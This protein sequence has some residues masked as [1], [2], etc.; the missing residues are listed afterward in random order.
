MNTARTFRSR[1][2]KMVAVG[3]GALVVAA[4]LFGAYGA[5]GG[6]WTSASPAIEYLVPKD[7]LYSLPGGQFFDVSLNVQK[8]TTVSGQFTNTKGITL[9][10]MTPTE[11]TYLSEKGT[12][13]SYYW[14][15]GRIAN[16][17]L[18]NFNYTFAPGQWGLV[19]LNADNP[20][21]VNPSINTTIVTI[22]SGLFI[23]PS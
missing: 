14:T 1:R 21:L 3:L 9:Y 18:T 10:V 7:S 15:S 12:V 8:S 19:F 11:V 22:Y 4:A 13:G 20:S 5:T 2:G 17:T 16:L 23:A 6:F